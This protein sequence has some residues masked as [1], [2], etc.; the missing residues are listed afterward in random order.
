MTDAELAIV[1][2]VHR[3]REIREE[4]GDNFNLFPSRIKGEVFS[5]IMA[6]DRMRLLF[7]DN[8]NITNLLD[9]HRKML[10][11]GRLLN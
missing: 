9:E 7:N 5:L 3:V 11:S 8:H 1:F 10:S 2:I 6:V 4:H